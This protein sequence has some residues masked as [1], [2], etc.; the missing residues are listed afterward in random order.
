MKERTSPDWWLARQRKVKPAPPDAA[1]RDVPSEESP[2]KRD[3]CAEPPDAVRSTEEA[4]DSGSRG[5]IPKS[6]SLRIVIID[7]L[8]IENELHHHVYFSPTAGPATLRPAA[9]SKPN[10]DAYLSD[11]LDDALGLDHLDRQIAL[12]GRIGEAGHTVV[13][14][15]SR[16]QPLAD[17]CDEAGHRASL[18]RFARRFAN[19][20]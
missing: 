17:L 7:W 19:P 15:S 9:A 10:L 3:L 6:R 14:A 18:R 16:S 11:T 4:F 8:E 5:H 2:I 1:F 13:K 12:R 20:S